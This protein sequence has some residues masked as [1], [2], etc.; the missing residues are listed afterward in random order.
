MP[1]TMRSRGL[2]APKVARLRSGDA[3]LAPKGRKL[4]HPLPAGSL[5]SLPPLPPVGYAAGGRSLT[6]APSGATAPVPP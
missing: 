1:S 3:A 4:R 6:L 5:R 2:R